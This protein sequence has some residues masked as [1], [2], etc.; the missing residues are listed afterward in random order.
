MVRL[1]AEWHSFFYGGNFMTD[2]VSF[3]D[4]YIL[5]LPGFVWARVPDAPGGPRQAAVS[6]GPNPTWPPDLSTQ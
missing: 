4:A 5:S 3:Q 6:D 2:N 1:I